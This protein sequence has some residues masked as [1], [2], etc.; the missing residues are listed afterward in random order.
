[1]TRGPSSKL[2][3]LEFEAAFG[4]SLKMNL[5]TYY[6]E[7]QFAFHKHPKIGPADGSLTPEELSAWVAFAKPLGIQIL[8]NQQSFGHFG[9]ILRHAEYAKLRETPDI[10]CPVNDDSYKLLDDMYSEVCPLLP[11]PFFNVCCDET[12]GLGQGPSKGL[13]EKIGIGGVYVRHIRRIHDILAEKYKK[14]MMMWGDIILQHPKNLEQIPKDTLMLTWGYDGRENFENQIIPFARS[15]YEFFVCPGVSDWSRI[16]PDF[17]VAMTNIGNFVRDGVK[18]GALGM[19]NTDWEDDGEALKAVKWHAD[20]W[21][22]EC[23]WNASKTSRTDFQR[24]V[25]A[26]LFGEKGDHFGQAVE[27]LATTHRMAGMDGMNNRRFWQNDFLPQRDPITI[28]TGAN[29][30]LAAVRPA[31]EHL[32]ACRREAVV[33]QHIL[34]VFLF[35]ARRMEFIGQRMLDGLEAAELY[36]KAYDGPASEAGPRLAKVETL[37]RA[38]RNAYKAFDREFAALWTKESKPYALDHTM[39]R[40]QAAI[41]RDD[42]LL[43]KLADAGKCLEG[44]KPLPP[45]EKLGLLAPSIYPRLKRPNEKVSSPLAPE[46]PW[47]DRS[48]TARF[49]LVVRAGSVDRYELP[50]EVEVPLPDNRAFHHVSAYISIAGGSTQE[51]PAQLERGN[52]TEPYHLAMLI[53]SR[54]PKGSQAMVHVYLSAREQ[55]QHLRQEVSV[56]DAPNDMMWLENDKV[57]LLVGPE[58]AHVYRW[59]LKAMN[60][61]DLTMPGESDWM[62]FADAGREQRHVRYFLGPA[63][64]GP[65]VARFVCVTADNQHQVE[66]MKIISL[67]AGVSWIEVV[68]SEPVSYYWDFDNPKNFAADGPTPGQYLF[69]NGATGAREETGRRAGRPGEGRPRGLGRQVQQGQAG[70]GAGHSRDDARFHHRAWRRIWRRRH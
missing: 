61:R 22:A 51:M 1:M 10:L 47:A 45:P 24:R 36:T 60:N 9:N 64:T 49:G 52:R 32:E 28:T 53:P 30:L 59:E 68:L 40:Y 14:R 7:H 18:H 4:A 15:G 6:M 48:A 55:R 17:G 54:I 43:K 16:L 31:I 70:P 3:T 13:A 56:R 29:R 33:N 67:Y 34:D 46:T 25:G 50:V 20:A 5:M 12:D 37:V 66:R 39:A 44:H 69:A 57:R 23:A 35:G 62:G 21:A 8:G 11:F 38:N 2:E 65:A 63:A 41:A 58:G 42:Q 26:V 19:L 27:L